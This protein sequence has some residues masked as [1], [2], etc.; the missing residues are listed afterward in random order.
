MTANADAATGR[1]AALLAALNPIRNSGIYVF[2][3]VHEH[4]AID[5]SRCLCVMHESHATSV[6]TRL[7]HL[8][9]NAVASD[10]HAAWITLAV[11]SR[12]TDI[13]LTAAVSGC[14]ADAGIRHDHLFVPV[15]AATRA[16]A[17]L[18]ARQRAAQDELAGTDPTGTPP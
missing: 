9:E 7:E 1:S 3:P 12:L 14:L 5:T 16:M 17:V 2:A 8:P 10:Y 13:G 11:N 15:A 4:A 18:E 6:I